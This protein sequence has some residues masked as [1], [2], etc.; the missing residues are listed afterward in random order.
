VAGRKNFAGRS[1]AGG[2]MKDY[3]Y[4]ALNQSGE[5]VT[6]IHRASAVK[7]LADDLSAQDLILIGSRQTLGSFGH[8]FS[9]Y[10]RVDRR[11]LRDFTLHMATCLSAGIPVMAALIDFELDSARGAFKNIA[12]DIRRDISS[13]AQVDEALAKYPEVFSETYIALIA[14]GQSCGDLGQAFSSLVEHLEW[15]QDLRGTA[16]Q[17][18]VYPALMVA[19]ITGLF[20]LMLFYVLPRFMEIFKYQESEL[21]PVTLLVMNAFDWLMIWWPLLAGAAVAGAAGIF[22]LR[23]SREGRYLTDLFLLRLPVAGGFIHKLS[24]SRFSRY[25]SL[26]FRSGTSLLQVLELLE[27]VLGNS[28]LERELRVIRDRV[29]TGETLAASFAHSAYFPPLIQ[30]LIGVGET[31]GQLDRAL[32]KAADYLDKEIPRALQQAFTVL[33]VFIIALLGG[34]IAVA[35][36]SILLPIMQMGS[37][38]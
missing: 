38:L 3:R 21:P 25:F 14:A 4:R 37:M 18:L 23:R 17:A 12:G 2:S 16:K 5:V 33:N 27:K 6:G 24:L 22:L 32:S 15:L 20:M 26:L 31:T 19:G 34:L 35:A 13:G 29:T 10:G 8:H 7:E 36:L 30:R 9:L 28:V 11:E 1:D